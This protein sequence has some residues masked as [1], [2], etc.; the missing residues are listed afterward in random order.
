MVKPFEDAAF[1]LKPGE[2]SGVVETQ[3][4]FHILKVE[5]R[6]D[7][8]IESFDAVK[9][10]LRQKLLQ[11]RTRQE[12]TEFIDKAMLDSKAELY[13]DVLMGEKK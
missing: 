10:R 1:S 13:P 8:T 2:V 11:D 6:K 3:F 7:S 12:I 5:D 9:E 4:G